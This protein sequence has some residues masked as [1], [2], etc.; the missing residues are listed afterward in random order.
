MKRLLL[1][2]DES[3]GGVPSAPSQASPSQPAPTDKTP[4]PA[5]Q[6]VTSGTKTEREVTLEKDL[7]KAH[8]DLATT[9]QEKKDKEMRIMELEDQLFRLKKSLE[10]EPKK[11]AGSSWRLTLLEDEEEE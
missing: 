11:K 2:P 9:A 8:G 4:P 7:A 3:G 1:S 6:T 10:P 5:A